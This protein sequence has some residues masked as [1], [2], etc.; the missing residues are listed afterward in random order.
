MARTRCTDPLSPEIIA[1]LEQ[2]NRGEYFEQHETLELVWRAE[3]GRLRELYKGIIQVGVGLHHLRRHNYPGA[4][5][6]LE[7]GLGHL[8]PYTPTCQGID[9]ERLISEGQR[10]LD[11]V[12]ALSPDKVAQFDWSLAPQ[13]HWTPIVPVPDISQ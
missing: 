12:L 11:A 5:H 7:R 13:V 8:P 9:V 2:F 3:Y 1:G 4:V 10:C 6:L